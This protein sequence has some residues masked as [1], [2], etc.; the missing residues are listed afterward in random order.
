ME[1]QLKFRFCSIYY[2]DIFQYTSR[3]F[4]FTKIYYEIIFDKTHSITK[5][6]MILMGKNE[7]VFGEIIPYFVK[8]NQIKNITMSQN[9]SLEELLNEIE[10]YIQSFRKSSVNEAK[11]P[12]VISLNHTID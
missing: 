2:D 9:K 12:I 8:Q 10:E 6:N 3:I 5:N 1:Y 4:N 11:E 7:L